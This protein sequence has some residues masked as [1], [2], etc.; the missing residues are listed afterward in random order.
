MLT[1]ILIVAAA[2]LALAAIS[3]RAG[4]AFGYDAA[5]RACHERTARIQREKQK[6][7]DSK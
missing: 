5:L 2:S 4:Y 3:F 1:A 6:L 7:S